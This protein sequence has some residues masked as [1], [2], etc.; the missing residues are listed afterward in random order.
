M[1]SSR[2]YLAIV[3]KSLPYPTQTQTNYRECLKYFKMVNKITMSFMVK[4]ENIFFLPTCYLNYVH[5]LNVQKYCRIG[6]LCTSTYAL[7]I[8][9]KCV[10][11]IQMY[12]A[13]L[14]SSPKA[15]KL[16]EE[17]TYFKNDTEDRIFTVF[18]NSV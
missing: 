7:H 5:S 10:F 3:S 16:M 9:E 8:L 6:I 13:V 17:S 14:I 2:A 1:I 4:Y 12:C 15:L 18:N 11:S